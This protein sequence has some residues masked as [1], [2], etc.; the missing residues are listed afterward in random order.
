MES[1]KKTGMLER[2]IR[3]GENVICIGAGLMLLGMMF[4]GAGDVVGRYLFN[5]PITG[6]MEISQ[7]LMG[8]S[9]FLAL[10]Y[11]HA[12]KAHVSVDIVFTRYPPR[13]RAI[14]TSIMMFISFVLFAL[15]TWQSFLIAMS[16]L[17]SGKLVRVIL[18]PLGPFKFL[19][20]LGALF[21]SLECIIQMFHSLPESFG[22]KKD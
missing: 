7:L 20:P 16:D 11:T 12:E 4:I 6:A 14:L 22:R 18:I 10:A 21:I 13:V 15:I 17:A 8:G 1:N 2:T 3:T 5:R 9:I 19:L